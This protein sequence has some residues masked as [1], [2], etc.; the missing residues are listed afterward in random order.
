M[1]D[2]VQAWKQL[3]ASFVAVI[4]GLSPL[5]AALLIVAGVAALFYGRRVAWVFTAL[6]GFMLGLTVGP[7][8][9]GPLPGWLQ[10]V[11]VLAIAVVAGFLGVA[12]HRAAS[13]VI[14]ALAL[15]GIARFASAYLD[16][17]QWARWLLVL[18]GALGGVLL[19][20]V[21][22]ES[23]LIAVSAFYGAL[24]VTVGA[25]VTITRMPATAEVSVF[26]LLLAAGL[27]WQIIS[28]RQEQEL[29]IP[30][31][32]GGLPAKGDRKSKRQAAK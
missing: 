7:L 26:L 29:V 13:V 15:A 23:T 8:V 31:A 3:T 18:L 14:G 32:A 28:Y 4:G 25:R 20:R 24:A 12:A 16:L 17:A 10:Q 2:F 21:W 5:V 9:A 19:I 22:R 27:T 11:I 1:A 6:M 30:A